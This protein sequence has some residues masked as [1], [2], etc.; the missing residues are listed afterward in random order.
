MPSIL[1]AGNLQLGN[2]SRFSD[3]AFPGGPQSCTTEF[4]VGLRWRIRV[5]GLPERPVASAL[6]SSVRRQSA[7]SRIFDWV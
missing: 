3:L 1:D 5:R 2:R 6:R 4:F 7:A